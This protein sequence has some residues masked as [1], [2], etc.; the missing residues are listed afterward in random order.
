LS[1]ASVLNPVMAGENQARGT[2]LLRQ[3]NADMAS[4]V[5]QVRGSLVGVSNGRRGHGAGTIWHPQGL[6]LTNAHVVAGRHH[7]RVT[8]PDGETLLASLLAADPDLDLAALSVEAEGLPTIEVGQSK[9]MVAGDVVIA[10]GHPWGVR[11]AATAG[12]FI[13]MSDGMPEG[14]AAGRELIAVSLHLRPGHSGGPLVDAR[15][16]LIGINTMMAGPDV[17]VAVPAHVIKRF[18]KDALGA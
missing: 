4:V 11:G 5:S 14:P 6:I 12:V 17:G 2:A 7:L 3:L 8:L 10:L 9:N 1:S 18:L 15:G 13:A 16:R